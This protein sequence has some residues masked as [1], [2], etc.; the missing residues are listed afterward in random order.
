MLYVASDVPIPLQTL[1]AIRI[2]EISAEASVVRQWL[3][4]PQVR[5]VG[6]HTGCGCGFPS[7]VAEEPIEYYPEMFDDAEDRSAD[8]GSVHALLR[9]ID[10]LLDQSEMV[11]LFPVWA[12]DEAIPPLGK[13]SVSRSELQPETFFFTAHFIYEVRVLC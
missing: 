2:E 4:L 5:L 8:I 10:R 6:A 7:V 12:G 3:T 1:D 11:E 13:V 9:T